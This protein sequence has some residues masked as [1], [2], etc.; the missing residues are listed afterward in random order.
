MEPLKEGGA[1]LFLGATRTGKTTR[2]LHEQGQDCARLGIPGVI[3]DLGR[4]ATFRVYPHTPSVD[5]VLQKLYVERTHAGVWTPESDDARRKFWA[6]V[7]RWGGVAVLVDEIANICSAYKVDDDFVLL[8]NQHA[9]GALGPTWLYFTAQRLTYVNPKLYPSFMRAYLFWPCVGRERVVIRDEFGAESLAAA[10]TKRKGECH[11]IDLRCPDEP[12]AP[13][14]PPGTLPADQ[15]TTPD[16][17]P[18]E[19][20]GQAGEDGQDP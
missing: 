4:A 20:G 19:G 18:P 9:H 3:L 6:A 17:P 10:L 12:E 16:S 13:Q 7:L 14:A 11:V 5:A 2:A 1:Q 15:R 8:S